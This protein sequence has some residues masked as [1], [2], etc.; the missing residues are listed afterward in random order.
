MRLRLR[1]AVLSR[2]DNLG[3]K[4]LKAR[5]YLFIF[6]YQRKLSYNVKDGLYHADSPVNKTAAGKASWPRASWRPGGTAATR[7]V[8]L[9]K[10]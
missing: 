6:I 9:E 1:P 8:Q 2:G 5:L 10:R 3:E 7:T 4:W